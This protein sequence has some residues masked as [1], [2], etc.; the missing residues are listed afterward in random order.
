MIIRLITLLALTSSCG[1]TV[2]HK[3]S[4]EVRTVSDVNIKVDITGIVE[5]CEQTIKPDVCIIDVIVD[6]NKAL[7]KFS[8]KTKKDK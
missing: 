5:L 1:M 8:D 6:L 4:G 2:R 3:V 7:A